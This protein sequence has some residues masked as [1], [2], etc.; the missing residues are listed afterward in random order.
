MG[1]IK[2]ILHEELENSKK[3]REVYLKNLKKY[4][5]GSFQKKK[6]GGNYYYYVAHRDGRKVVYSYIGKKISKEDREKLKKLKLEK[7]RYKKQIDK[8]NKQ[9][10]FLEKALGGSEDV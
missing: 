10:K 1:V 4:H 2:G 3:M 6:I 5:V 7:N 9:I 8:V